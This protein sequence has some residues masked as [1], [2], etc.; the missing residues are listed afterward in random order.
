MNDRTSFAL[1]GRFAGESIA[2]LTDVLDQQALADKPLVFDLSGLTFVD[3]A[4][5]AFLRQLAGQG[6]SMV[7]AS[8]FVSTL[9]AGS[10][11]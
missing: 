11:I 1:E 9:L 3:L 8:S 4:G 10:G 7:G 6:V 5:A 2:E